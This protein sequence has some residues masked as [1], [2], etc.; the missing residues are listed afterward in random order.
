MRVFFTSTDQFVSLFFPSYSSKITRMILK[1]VICSF[2]VSLFDGNVDESGQN[3]LK[4]RVANCKCFNLRGNCTKLNNSRTVC[5]YFSIDKYMLKENLESEDR[6][7]KTREWLSFLNWYAPMWLYVFLYTNLM[8]LLALQVN[9]N[10]NPK[11]YWN[12]L[13]DL[14]NHTPK[15]YYTCIWNLEHHKFVRTNWQCYCH[16]NYN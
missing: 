11:S 1:K 2:L 8:V 14:Q 9:T 7:W 13:L 10:H 12:L 4:L 3:C 6:R 15:Q 16:T 5:T